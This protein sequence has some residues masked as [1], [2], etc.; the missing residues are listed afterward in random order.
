VTTGPSPGPLLHQGKRRAASR[1]L[2]AAIRSQ[3][4]VKALGGELGRPKGGF[5]RV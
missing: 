2:E 3:P 4:T 5:K 1:H